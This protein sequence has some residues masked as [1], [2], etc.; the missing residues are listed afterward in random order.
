MIISHTCSSA[1]VEEMRGWKYE[2]E[3]QQCDTVYL[4]PVLYQRVTRVSGELRAAALSNVGLNIQGDHTATCY[5]EQVHLS[6]VLATD[7]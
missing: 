4:C 6:C 7:S 5:H 3:G 1:A 2:G